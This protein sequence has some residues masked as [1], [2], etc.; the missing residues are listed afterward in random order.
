MSYYSYEEKK[1]P[2]GVIVAIIVILI[3]AIFMGSVGSYNEAEYVMTVT[4]KERVADEDGSKYLIF[5]ED[6]NGNSYVFENTD[7]MLR[8]KWDSSNMYGEIKIGDTYKFTVVGYR[9]PLFSSYQNIIKF[10]EVQD[11]DG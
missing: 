11:N 10:S 2:L 6:E 5:G 7:N 3:V 9:I 1:Y 8:G 4:E